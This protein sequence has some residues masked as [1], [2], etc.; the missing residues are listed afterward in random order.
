MP[1]V[2]AIASRRAALVAL[3]SLAALLAAAV[4]ALTPAGAQSPDDDPSGFA[5]N[6]S[7]AED[8]DN[9]V[10]P[11]GAMTVA[12]TVTYSGAPPNAR[13]A[14]ADEKYT[15][16]VSE[17]SLQIA[18]GQRW[19]DRGRTGR[20]IADL[21]FG[22]GEG[23]DEWS[24]GLVPVDTN[25][26]ALPN[27]VLGGFHASAWDGRTMVTR[28]VPA[29]DQPSVQIYDTSTNPPTFKA[30]LQDP[31]S[32]SGWHERFGTGRDDGLSP[33]VNP[34]AVWHETPSVAWLFIGSEGYNDEG[35]GSN[36][37]GGG[38][39]IYKLTYDDDGELTVGTSATD[40]AKTLAPPRTETTNRRDG[41]TPSNSGN[42]RA[43]YGSSL[44]I[45]ADGSTLA[46]V[47]KQINHVGALYVYT[48]PSSGD[49]DDITYA[50]GVKVTPVVVPSWGTG[51]S[52]PFTPGADSTCN[53]YCRLVTA[54]E[55]R[56]GR[57]S[58]GAT[59][60][61]ANTQ[62]GVGQ[63]GISADGSVIVVGAPA[64]QYANDTAAN[65][66]SG[67]VDNGEVY[68][69]EAPAGGWSSAE[70]V[71]TSR[72]PI[73][74]NAA[75][76][77]FDP[78]NNY[79][80]GPNKRIEAPTATL[81]PR[82]MY[83]SDAAEAENFGMAVDVSAD[84]S[85]IVVSSGI[86]RTTSVGTA[87]GGEAVNNDPA[88]YIFERSGSGW[89]STT[90][91]TA[92]YTIGDNRRWAAWGLQISAEGDTVIF[93]QTPYWSP[94]RGRAVVLKEDS[95]WP[96]FDF[97]I[98]AGEFPR[99]A[100]HYEIRQPFV[101]DPAYPAQ[102]EWFGVP[103]YD[104]Q[105]NR[106]AISATGHTNRNN[107]PGK[108]WIF[109]SNIGGCTTRLLD[110]VRT[111]TCQLDVGNGRIVIPPGTPEGTFTISGSMKIAPAGEEPTTVQ[112]ELVV[113]IGTVDEVASASLDLATDLGDVTVS[114][115][116]K[117][118]P[119]T[120]KRKGDSTRLLLSVLNANGKAS[121]RGSVAS[122]L[123]TTSAG[124]LGLLDSSLA[125]T[126]S[127]A[128]G[129]SCQ[130]DV[131]KVTAAN[132][133]RLMFT[134]THGGRAGAA[135]VRATVFSTAGGT[136]TSEPVE[137]TLAGPAESISIAAATRSVLNVDAGA[138]D[139]DGNVDD[140]TDTRDRLLLA[141]T[142]VDAA[143]VSVDV[144]PNRRRASITDSEG[145]QVTS[146]VT[147]TFPHV[148]ADGEPVLTLARSLQAAIEVNRSA[149]D[150]L[151]AGEYTLTVSAGGKT[152]TQTFTATGGPASDGITI[153]DPGSPTVDETFSV[154][155]T[156][157]DAEGNAVPD[158]TV[159]TWA[160]LDAMD[161]RLAETTLAVQT[162]ATTLTKDG[163][164]TAEY[165]AVDAG[166]VVIKVTAGSA[167]ATRRVD[168]Q[169]APRQPSEDP[170]DDLTNRNPAG[171]SVWLGVGETSASAL[172]SR[173]D[174][175]NTLGVWMDGEWR[176]YT[177][178]ASGAIGEDFS[179]M[180]GT[181]LWVDLR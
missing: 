50:E 181:L 158:G 81:R 174:G 66:F 71:T 144:P 45:S 77:S 117:P 128:G 79:S 172:L 19:E 163:Q 89:S 73:A 177:T 57:P 25:G 154:T 126:G 21:D 83:T 64:K 85:T 33:N 1:F 69:F 153:S 110:G 31:S 28:V 5:F 180:P 55:R 52:R 32:R 80:P 17:G 127:C 27:S 63:I 138:R 149:A 9:I 101:N 118:Y 13:D 137:V 43:L 141:V 48:R 112:G 35:S 8:S 170:T 24:D 84:G 97:T 148:D 147:A 111:N 99:T 134:L 90:S 161:V 59:A 98:R 175:P 155:V 179:V 37:L 75:A 65:E 87:G 164:V 58:S 146:G 3:G 70:D 102:S 26:N 30:Q 113:T 160:P 132:A 168:L 92:K 42:R 135:T 11:G 119:S 38:V 47:A 41:G 53:A 173:L 114:R 116:D 54:H 167:S 165:L 125:G 152:A 34:V 130:L 68:V 74:S 39:H 140:A 139:E 23:V 143:G 91:P 76:A 2:F 14:R 123:V 103:L 4:F 36:R 166:S 94:N 86:P 169:P 156:V 16:S 100:T 121:A 109:E 129:L 22:G 6:I 115:D 49:W 78:A 40:P 106:L 108:V 105:G 124:S 104:L 7:L 142:A 136:Y 107:H 44:A 162:S 15:V 56:E 120:L 88:V 12:A 20:T 60:D 122:V 46:V 178:T 145:K 131:S 157:Q 29:N 10:P 95:G 171:L 151:P 67:G 150:P 82:A 61:Y 72:T 62:F 93:G 159:V 96:S 133:D 51:A 18:G 176:Y